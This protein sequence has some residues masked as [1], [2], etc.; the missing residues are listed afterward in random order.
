LRVKAS[1]VPNVETGFLKKGMVDE[2]VADIRFSRPVRCRIYVNVFILRSFRRGAYGAI[3]YS[4]EPE[5]LQGTSALV[6]SPAI[7]RRALYIYIFISRVYYWDFP[8]LH[9]YSHCAWAW[10][11]RRCLLSLAG[12]QCQMRFVR[13]VS[14]DG[15]SYL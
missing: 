15:V 5:A 14:T 3:D 13:A 4:F 7:A 12:G 8:L 11:S 9:P 6:S 2:I 1:F 10:G